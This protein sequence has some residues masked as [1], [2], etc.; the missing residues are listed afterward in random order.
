MK[1]ET[2]YPGCT[3][4]DK[5]II[6]LLEKF[7]ILIMERSFPSKELANVCIFTNGWIEFNRD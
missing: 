6:Y 2:V 3:L 7:P 1:D 4:A 5:T